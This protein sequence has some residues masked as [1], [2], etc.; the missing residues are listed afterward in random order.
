VRIEDAPRGP[1]MV[2]E[3]AVMP[4]VAASWERRILA[5]VRGLE[6]DPADAYFGWHRR[7]FRNQMLVREGAPEEVALRMAL[8]LQREGR[9]RPLQD[10]I[11]GVGPR[12]LAEAARE[13]GDPR[14]LVF[15]PD[16]AA[17]GGR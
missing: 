15:G 14:V 17:D 3:A 6:R 12:E 7:R 8:D 16:L 1:V 2:V 11:W 9:V 4:E 13:L 10:E 5:T